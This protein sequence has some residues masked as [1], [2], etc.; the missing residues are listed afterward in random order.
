MITILFLPT[1]SLNDP[2]TGLK[3]IHASA[4][5][6]NIEPISISFKPK[7]LATGG[8]VINTND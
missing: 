4:D 1:E 3:I 5:V 8:M 6:A 7:S 2:Q